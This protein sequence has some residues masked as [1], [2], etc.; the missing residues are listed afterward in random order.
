MKRPYI[1]IDNCKH[2]LNIQPKMLKTL[3]L[4][5]CLYLFVMPISLGAMESVF[6]ITMA[7]FLGKEAWE[8]RLSS[9]QVP[10]GFRA[11]LLL[12][13][14][15]VVS[16]CINDLPFG[17]ARYSI[18]KIRWIVS[19]YLL[20]NFLVKI[21][22][23][24]NF[25]KFLLIASFSVFVTALYG[26]SQYWTGIDLVRGDAFKFPVAYSVNTIAHR[27]R[28]I[29]FYNLPLTYG[30]VFGCFGI[31][32]LLGGMAS[33]R[34]RKTKTFLWTLC[35]FLVVSASLFTTY[36]RGVWL[37]YFSGLGALLFF[38]DKKATLIFALISIVGVV[39]LA[40]YDS[41][42]SHRLNSIFD[43]KYTSNSQRVKI[44]KASLEMFKESPW[45]GVG[46]EQTDKRMQ[47]YF[48][49]ENVKDVKPTHAHNTYLQFLTGTG[50]FGLL[51]F[52][53]FIFSIYR[54]C[55]INLKTWPS[56][57]M[58]YVSLVLLGGLTSICVGGLTECNFKD[59]EVNH[60][61]VF[62]L[63]IFSALTIREI[64]N[65]GSP[66]GVLPN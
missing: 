59:A 16:V 32:A 36:T 35:L 7:L 45:F 54:R 9:W 3:N 20:S 27:W 6:W 11:L 41:H 37:A 57:R 10:L 55:F 1:D 66:S 65:S 56:G 49:K 2:S 25:Y 22:D 61:A 47:Y 43:K 53:L 14:A 60:I 38:W 62:I 8:G 50:A 58:F 63:S 46:Y 17:A 12:F 24:E 5:L 18:G 15:A 40:N 48:D 42:F 13:F 26:F 4:L 33:F 30:Y 28:T 19:Y 64:A 34:K 21:F 44:W 31:F 23:E 29:G 52:L 51:G 39:S